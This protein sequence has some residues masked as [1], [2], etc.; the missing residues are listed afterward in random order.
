MRRVVRMSRAQL[1]VQQ[2][3]GITSNDLHVPSDYVAEELILRKK[4]HKIKGTAGPKRQR[5]LQAARADKTQKES[6]IKYM[7][8]EGLA[9]RPDHDSRH[10]GLAVLIRQL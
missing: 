6:K 7:E 3:Q 2:L 5:L 9:S 4:C 1:T 8:M 10:S